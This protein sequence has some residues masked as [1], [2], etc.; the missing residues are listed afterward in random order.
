MCSA[1]YA[2]AH[3]TTCCFMTIWANNA[4]PLGEQC[5]YMH[6]WLLQSCS[7]S[8]PAFVM[9]STRLSQHAAASAINRKL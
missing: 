3:S 6:R 2:I 1:F 7:S 8:P 5:R 4:W 9:L